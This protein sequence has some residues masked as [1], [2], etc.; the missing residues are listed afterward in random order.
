MGAALG[1]APSY[2]PNAGPR[3]DDYKHLSVSNN[4]LPMSSMQDGGDG[5]QLLYLDGRE[6]WR[7]ALTARCVAQAHQAARRVE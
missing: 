3:I 6:I 5:A 4:L 2:V 1:S 7:Q